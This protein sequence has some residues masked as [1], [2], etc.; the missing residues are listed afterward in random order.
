M[1]VYGHPWS[2][3]TRKVLAVLAEKGQRAELV[4]VMVPY[5][6]H[7]QPAHVA[8]HPFG[9]VPTL[10]A[11]G[12]AVYE[13]GAINRFLDR[14]LDG[15]SL[16]GDARTAARADQWISASDSYF[17]PHAQPLIVETMFRRF[18]G[19]APDTAAIERATAGIQAPLDTIDCWL[20]DHPY[21]AGE[22]FTIADI[23]WMPYLDY[24][25]QIGHAA[26]VTGRS[27]VR[28]WWE[29]VSAR[30]AWRQVAHT[31]PQPYDPGVTAEVIEQRY[32]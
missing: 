30:P 15:P 22:A 27:N 6:E 9:K 3:N 18:L 28:S 31:G 2:I 32:R 1:K 16:T 8:R 13:T 21:L 4:L 17:A 7:K 20:A 29:R 23:H 26:A 19:G 10:E 25:V 12:F 14:T 24:L 5:G 11:E